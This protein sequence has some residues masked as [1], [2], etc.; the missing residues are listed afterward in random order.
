[1]KR[2]FL[3]AFCMLACN[4]FLS[5][6]VRVTNMKVS[7][8]NQPLGI[9]QTPT[10]SWQTESDER[11]FVQ[12]SYEIRVTDANGNTVWQTGPVVSA[13]QSN[14]RYEGSQLSSLSAYRWSVIVT[15][16]NGE[17][18]EAGA[19]TFETAFM[20][21]SEWTAKWIGAATDSVK[22]H[23][24]ISFDTPF[25]GRYLKIDVTKLGIPV[26]TEANLYYLQLAEVEIFSGQENVAR[27]AKFTASDS[28]EVPNYWS[29]KYINDGTLTTS[30]YGFTT[31]SSNNANRHIYINVDLGIERTID[32][33]VMYPRQDQYSKEGSKKAANFPA[34]FTVQSS[35]DN[36]DFTVRYTATNQ[37]APAYTSESASVPYYGRSF[38]VGEEI[39]RARIYATALGVFTMK[40]NGQPVTENRLEPGESE[41]TKSIQYCTYDVTK[42]LKQGDNTLLAQVAGGI[43]NVAKVGAN[44][45][46]TERYCKE[47]T[48]RGDVCLKAELHIDYSDGTHE[49]I[50]TDD[51]WRTAPS[52]T[53]GVNWW[54]G[55]DY[56]ATLEIE[57]EKLKIEDWQAVKVIDTPHFS[58]G[59]SS[60][61]IG[62]LR[63]R[64]YEP[65]RVVEEWKAVSVTQITVSGKKGY[66]VDFGKNFAGTFRFNLKGQRGQV[67]TLRTGHQL[68]N[69]KTIKQETFNS[70]PYDIYDT[71]TFAGTEGG[72]QWGPEFMYHGTRYLQIL[73]LTEAPKPEQFTALRLRSNV[74]QTGDFKTANTL[75]ND[76]H[77]ICRDAIQSQIYNSFTDCPHREKLG[78]LDVPNELYF[79]IGYNYDMTKFWGK[80]VQDCFDAQYATGKVPSTVPHFHGDWD[81]DP[82][83]GGSA[84]FIPYRNWKMYGDKSLMIRYYDGM[85]RLINYYTGMTKG[86]IMPGASYSALSDWGQGS[87]GLT[88]QIPAEFTITTSYYFLLNAMSEMAS[89]LGHTNDATTFTETAK[90]VKEAFNKRFYNATTHVYDYGNQGDYGMP[91]Y[92]GLVP[93]GD[94]QA[95]ADKL[96]EAVRNAKYKIKTGE[97][98]LKPVLM[99]LAKYGY[100][101]IVYQMACQTDYPSYGYWVKQGCTTTPELWNMQYS[102]NHC[103][104]DHIEEW[105]YSQLGGIQMQDDAEGMGFQHFIIRPWIP[106]NMNTMS[107]STKSLYGD[108]VSEYT[109]I[110]GS[111]QY[112][113][114]VPSN[115]MATITLPVGKQKLFENGKEVTT[116]TSG[117]SSINY[118]D[119]LVT[120]TVGSGDY[121][122]TT[123]TSQTNFR[124]TTLASPNNKISASVEMIEGKPVLQVLSN[125]QK[126]VER[127]DLGL[128]LS[129]ADFSLNLS[130]AEIGEQQY[131]EDQYTTLHGKRST[132]SNEANALTV[133]FANQAGKK[134]GVELRA[135]NDGLC[136][137]YAIENAEQQQLTF[138]G[139]HTAYVLAADATRWLQKFVTSYEGDF[140]K[141]QEAEQQGAWNYP[142]LVK[143]ANDTYVLITE[144]NPNREYCSTH[145]S[146]DANKN[147]YRIAY[148]FQW[149]GNNQGAVQPVSKAELWTSPWR[150]LIMGGLKDIVE[151]TL[152]EDVSDATQMTQT[153]WIQ[154]G[155]AAWVYWAYNH[156]T[157]DYQICR[158]YVDLAAEMGWDYVLF[159]WEWDAMTNGGNLQDAA[160]YALSKGV[161][162]LIWY[163]SGGPHNNV[164]STPRD[165]FL[166]HE[167]RVKEL[168]WLKSLGFVGVKI[169]FFESDKQSM[170]AYYL[171]ILDDCAEAQM[172]VNFHGCT[173]P[174]GWSRTYP[175]LMSMEAVYG[176]EQYNNSATM[177][178]IASRVNCLLPYTRN[179]V[180]PMD[181]TPVAFTN[182]QHPH[183]TT[184]AHELALSVAFESGIQHWADRP[185][186]FL[187]L[188]YEAKQHMMTVP[189]AWDEIRF[190]DGY[191]GTHFVVARR[192]GN[193]WYIA[194]LNGEKSNRTMSV[195]LDFLPAGQHLMTCLSD[196]SDGSKFSITHRMVT[197]NE[198]LDI[199][200]L[201]QGGFTLV[202]GNLSFEQ[203]QT[204]IQEAETILTKAK[205]NVGT[206]PGQYES[207]R[208]DAL[209]VALQ[210]AKTVT[211]ISSE[212]EMNRAYITLADA[213]S[214]LQTA[215]VIESDSTQ[216]ECVQPK[217][218]GTD[219]TKQ[220]LGEASGFSRSDGPK[221]GS[222]YYRFGSPKSWIV[223]NYEIDNDNNGVKHGIDNFPG[224]NCLQ[225]G[226]WEESA[227]K[228]NAA[229]LSN[230]R[231]YQQVTLP[232]GRY[233]FGASYHY[234]E[235]NRIGS[236]A[237]IFVAD[238]T[239]YTDEVRSKALAYGTMQSA[240]LGGTLYG[241]EFT[242]PQEQEVVLGW[243]MD[244]RPEHS[245]FR[246]SR[247]QL[248]YYGTPVNT[249]ID[250]LRENGDERS[251]LYSPIQYYHLSG[252][253]VDTPRQHGM[254]IKRQGNKTRKIWR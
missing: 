209:E 18:S 102:Q 75:I 52:P 230:S 133:T 119:S 234:M 215:G 228:L 219:V 126:V 170:M 181:Y 221:S 162:P 14:I 245:E 35:T 116:A 69:N 247:V 53:T 138:T 51:N 178:D 5:A 141:Q 26:S 16:T 248:L 8:L 223:E 199:P 208:V 150:V 122:F 40:M 88:N 57:D 192:S 235:S 183:A 112:H 15:G 153:D 55:E 232:E 222:T 135:Y 13:A 210:T 42:L 224:Y 1:M 25:V 120:V 189:T 83:W 39:S 108:I 167:S 113:F 37:D 246:A 124:V 188:P 174:R 166:T 143:N 175:H 218:G 160:R 128:K 105:F 94:E 159:D 47:I 173:L 180:G 73:G 74:E 78:W 68:N 92:Y 127:I 2:F 123:G 60:G 217:N 29:I 149:E 177:T 194:G 20:D 80:T 158:Q 125:D 87:S 142:L 77:T 134:M 22:S 48:N 163:N 171:D 45:G 32:R 244:S 118:T 193:T 236:N 54:G 168:A 6:A 23:F 62:V 179:V 146:N 250:D 243:Q 229:D 21:P 186:G 200:C 97:I 191:P 28:Y 201:S 213:L 172:M 46:L 106:E 43:F 220:Y 203:L 227:N 65:I 12:R 154:G 148:P 226:R 11:G 111:L 144:A 139:E 225:L 30:H 249:G 114:A 90:K 79:S 96:A 132:C 216:G 36:K 157:K 164:S 71:Y 187:S 184:F 31:H 67:I 197:A 130:V 202:F 137:R 38:S 107:C 152:V 131:I 86:Y 169:D 206:K 98:A 66:L 195:P 129:G 190:I 121:R 99:S 117:V 58:C 238:N 44:G 70:W 9:D 212:E 176:A 251:D 91:L 214:A 4:T 136:F 196:G 233:F 110:G 76:I 27:T 205:D 182:S 59:Q 165:R 104:M 19:S 231:L 82:N 204:L 17:S 237:Y 239:L 63:S 100:N 85:K 242:L 185:E 24:D 33:I 103:M 7:G 72:E 61:P 140:P 252:R 84:I 151:S 95:V 156:G 34:S 147:S 109:R 241:V 56:D 81:D 155:S 49:V 89:E 93:E 101:D 50:V 41:F 64:S 240:A 145:I 207:G 211:N 198:Q 253:S 115:S 161:K 254:Y 3:L 10:F